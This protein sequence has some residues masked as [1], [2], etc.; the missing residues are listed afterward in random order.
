[1]SFRI[2][3]GGLPRR[4]RVVQPSYLQREGLAFAEVLSEQDIQTA[5]EEEVASFAQEEGDV[6]TPAITLWAFLS[7]S[8]SSAATHQHARTIR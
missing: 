6:Y 4:F 5:F 8:V 1:M 7:R 2:F 3:P